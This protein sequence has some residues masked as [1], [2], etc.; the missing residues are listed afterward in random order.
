MPTK[1]S[2]DTREASEPRRGRPGWVVPA[3]LAGVLVLG[4]AIGVVVP[5]GTP[6]SPDPDASVAATAV[7]EPMDQPVDGD[8]DEDEGGEEQLPTGAVTAGAGGTRTGPGGIPAGF[9]QTRDGAVAAATVYLEALSST[10]LYQPVV[11]QEILTA[12]GDPR[13]LTGQSRQIQAAI[14]TEARALGLTAAGEPPAGHV[15]LSTIRPTWGAYRV[16]A[17]TPQAAEIVIWHY[18]ERGV[19]PRDGD[20]PPGAW[21]TS[22]VRMTWTGADWK[23]AALPAHQDGPVPAVAPRAAPPVFERARLLGAAWWLYANTEV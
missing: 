13:W 14:A 4:I 7:G 1:I 12:T 23:L 21:R 19:V 9:A 22:T 20:P 6:R 18:L 5:G 16:A 17:Y 2:L 15:V 11:G 8:Q 10:G 3:L